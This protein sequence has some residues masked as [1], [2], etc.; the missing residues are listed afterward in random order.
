MLAVLSLHQCAGFSLTAGA[1]L[2][3][4][5]WASRC[6]GFSCCGAQALSCVGFRSC[7]TWPQ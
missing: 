3:G 4:S 2:H 5:M 7:C 1:V 6:G